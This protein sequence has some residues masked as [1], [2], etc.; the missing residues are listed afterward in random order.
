[1]TFSRKSIAQPGPECQQPAG[2]LSWPRPS[3]QVTGSTSPPGVEGTE[4]C[5]QRNHAQLASARIQV[6]GYH[7]D[8][9][10]GASKF[11]E[12]QE[13]RTHAGKRLVLTSPYSCSFVFIRG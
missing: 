5:F 12:H 10:Q 3:G 9:E 13:R 7:H 1:M 2:P 6:P 8:H 11:H 4:T